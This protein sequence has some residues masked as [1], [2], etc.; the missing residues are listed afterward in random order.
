MSH[1]HDQPPLGVVREYACTYLGINSLHYSEV[2]LGV[3]PRRLFRPLLQA[4]RVRGS[5]QIHEYVQVRIYLQVKGQKSPDLPGLASI[6]SRAQVWVCTPAE[7]GRVAQEPGDEF[8]NAMKGAKLACTNLWHQCL[9]FMYGTLPYILDYLRIV[10]IHIKTGGRHSVYKLFNKNPLP[11]SRKLLRVKTCAN[12]EVLW[13]FTKVFSTK[14][15][16][17]HPLAA[18]ASNSQKFFSVNIV[19]STNSRNISPSKIS[20]YTAVALGCVTGTPY[21]K[22]LS[23]PP[24]ILQV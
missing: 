15:G 8:P 2:W 24:M 3:Q 4:C 18:Q 20:H 23:R 21:W 16:V 10:C 19:F 11:Y 9:L 14:L 7:W 17:W 12:F 22:C 13:L 5:K 1:D 6:G